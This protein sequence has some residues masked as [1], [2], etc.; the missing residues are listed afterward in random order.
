MGSV[1][2]KDEERIGSEAKV[3]LQ[4]SVY[5]Q[6]LYDTG[7]PDLGWMDNMGEWGV[8]AK[9][10]NLGLRLKD[11]QIGTYGQIPDHG[12][13]HRSMAPRGAVIPEGLPSLGFT[14]N[15][16]AEVWADNAAELYEE[17]VARQ[18]SSARDIPWSEL[19]PLPD[20]LERAMCQLC[21]FLTE[22]E[23]IAADAPTRWMSQMNQDFFEV[24]MFLATQAMDEARHMDVFRKRALA[25]GGG[26]G[27]ASVLSELSLKRIFDAPSFSAQTG[28]LHLLGEGFVLTMFR[29]GEFIAPSRV[30][31][32]IFRRCMQDESRHVGYGTMHLRAQLRA[33]PDV[34]EEIH[35]Q[36]DD[37]E[38]I[39][40]ETFSIPESVEP[41][42]ILMGGGV[43]NFDKG[44]ELQGQL[45]RRIV[46]E[47]LQRCDSAGLDRRP[48]CILPTDFSKLVDTPQDAVVS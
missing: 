47:Y 43:K 12:G 20:D 9:P 4:P 36:L 30:D 38:R 11:I 13:D 6:K 40:L 19:K 23:F 34:A 25:N 44:M 32:E 7:T 3:K 17:A 29:Q 39:L 24:K 5:L 27:T 45:W 21:T 26:L 22:V 37:A 28:R 15:E 2:I 14:L 42:A 48:R 1:H 31:Q 10:G 41:M 8:R 46:H 33:N 18:W 35:E 16:K